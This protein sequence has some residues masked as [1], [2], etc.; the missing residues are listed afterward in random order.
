MSLDYAIFDVF[1]RQPLSGNPLA[2][3]FGA[4]GLNTRQLLSLAREFNLS[5]TVFIQTPTQADARARLR[6]FTPA[7][8]LPF[9]GHPIL[10]A[11]CAVSGDTR[12]PQTLPLQLGASTLPVHVEPRENA[13]FY[14]QMSA[15]QAPTFADG[16]PDRTTL[17]A[18]L[19]LDPDDLHSEHE[20]ARFASC[21]LPYLLVPVRTPEILS[22]ITLDIAAC[23]EQLGSQWAQALYVYCRGYEGELRARMFAPLLGVIEDPATGSAALALGAALARESKMLNGTLNWTIQQGLELSRPSEL[24]VRAERRDG[25]TVALHLG[26]HVVPIARG[27]LLQPN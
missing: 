4:D 10:G 12:T 20:S 13:L 23:R 14:A 18:L 22:S 6:I 8:E 7:R 1:T 21:G 3:V 16:A 24:Q 11:A 5:E 2:V 27:Q 15:T 19:G 25:A 17:A 9:A 26:G